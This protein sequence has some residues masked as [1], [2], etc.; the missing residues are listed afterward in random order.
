MPEQEQKYTRA[1]LKRGTRRPAWFS[2]AWR[3]G[4][5]VG[6][7]AFMVLFHWFER[8]GLVDELD[9]HISFLDAIYFTMI[10]ATT[11]GYGD[12]VPVT[13]RTRMFDALVVTPIRILFLIIFIGTAYMLVARRSWEKFLMRRIQ[14]S[15][16]GHT[17]IAGFGTKNRRALEELIKLGA[18]TSEI[19]VLDSD[20]ERLEI[21]KELGCS[22]MKADATRDGTLKAVHIERARLMLISA[23]RDDTSILICLTARDLAPDLRISV[24]INEQDNEAPARRAGADIVVNPLNFAGLLLA[25]S[26]GGQHIADYLADLASIGGKVQLVERPVSADEI[27][28]SLREATGGVGLRLIRG[29]VAYGFWRPQAAHL[30]HDDMIM[31][32]R[33]TN[34]DAPLPTA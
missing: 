32:I 16:E 25:T 1:T 31:E 23:G 22:V 33:P 14:R 7:L 4:A 13:D 19:V 2:I 21:A 11:T 18:D 20:E 29:G 8:D 3:I 9:G 30:E 28:K 24:A 15:L 27:G 34:P 12:I 6:L 10:S 17:I 26:H 5:V